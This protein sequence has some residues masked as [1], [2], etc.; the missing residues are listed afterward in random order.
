MFLP[1]YV[2]VYCLLLLVSSTLLVVCAFVA[3][4]VVVVLLVGNLCFGFGRVCPLLLLYV[5]TTLLMG[6]CWDSSMRK[7]RGIATVR[8]SS[9]HYYEPRASLRLNGACS[10]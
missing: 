5:Y 6:A 4:I 9:K 1:T 8:H 3:F 7:I 10:K 2:R